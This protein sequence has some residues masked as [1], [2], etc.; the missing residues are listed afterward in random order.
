MVAQFVKT[1][2]RS[3]QR[4][5]DRLQYKADLQCVRERP[6]HHIAREP[7]QNRNQAQPSATKP[8]IRDIHATNVIGIHRSDTAQQVGIDAM[9]RVAFAEIGPGATA[10]I[11][12]SCI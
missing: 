10:L 6:A 8:H 1:L 11:P 2:R 12:I 3:G 5:L 7:V 4:L 9:I